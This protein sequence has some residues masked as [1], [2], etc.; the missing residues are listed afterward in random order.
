MTDLRFL[1]EAVLWHE[2]MLLAPQ[3]FQ[4][5][6]LRQEGLL[7]YHAA[8]IAPF[9]WGVRRLEIDPALLLEGTFRVN[10]LEA[11]LPDGLIA[12]V[13]TKASE[14]L[15]LDLAPHAEAMK[16]GALT[17]H[18]AVPAQRA[19]ASPVRG[20]LPRYD[21]HE[22][23]LVA[24]ET[25]GDGDLRIPRL[26]PRLSLIAGDTPP[27]KYV[28][29][30]LAEV[31]YSNEAF[32]LTEFLPPLLQVPVS[33]PL[34]KLC[35]SISRR[36]REKAMF[37][38]ERARSPSVASRPPQL[39]ET[40]SMIQSLV[41]ALPQFEAVLATGVAH[42]YTLYLALTL[43]VGHSASLSRALVPPVLDP[44]DHNDPHAAFE[45][46]RRHLFRVIDEAILESYTAFPFYLEGGI[47]NLAF[48]ESW[49]ERSLVLGVRGQ[50]GLSEAE[51][52]AWMEQCLI[53]SKSHLQGMR[54]R[55]ILGA[56]RTRIEGEGD[57]VPASGVVLFSF[58]PDPEFVE[59]NQLLQI[60][61]AGDR[62]GVPRA[63]E[64]VLY[65]RNRR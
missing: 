24:D 2:G 28:S 16:A 7:H 39:L 30:P 50:A 43:L 26:R 15:E 53:G 23:E 20:E 36:V 58:R 48:D 40:R 41:A 9:Y 33:S 6:T 57:L 61:N 54:E 62:G 44:Y 13:G 59:P 18:L 3:H 37:L 49:R 12:S 14:S 27:R 25:T 45:R 21:S 11:I 56:P 47:F 10:E 65:V 29:F 63:S 8:A 17:I 19:G 55:R 52:A 5:L 42:P 34:G 31:A 60:W 64:I 22:G 35:G 38:A 4:Q 51:I 46:A 32:A 1:P